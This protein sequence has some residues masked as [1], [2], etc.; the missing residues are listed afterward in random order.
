MKPKKNKIRLRFT[1]LKNEIF[2]QIHSENHPYLDGIAVSNYGRVIS[3]KKFEGGRLLR[4]SKIKGY[5]KISIRDAEGKSHSVLLHHWV[6]KLFLKKPKKKKKHLI[7][8]DYNKGNNH[9]S[10]LKWVGEKGFKKHH[11]KNPAYTGKSIKQK[12]THFTLSE[13]QVKKLK[14]ELKTE[15]INKTQLAK[16][17]KIS[18][19]QVHRINAGLNWSH[20]Q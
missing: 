1:L 11:A 16:K 19:T 20:I 10:N 9:F 14:E 2:K 13:N 5:P 7:H 15:G 17:Y 8:R 6:A 4:G 3:F 18:V 12:I